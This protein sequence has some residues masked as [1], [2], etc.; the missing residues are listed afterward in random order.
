MRRSGPVGPPG[1]VLAATGTVVVG[2]LA[3][4]ESF[5]VLPAAVVAYAAA[6]WVWDLDEQS[7]RTPEEETP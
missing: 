6:W 4:T 3:L 1:V 7:P 5:S 2:T